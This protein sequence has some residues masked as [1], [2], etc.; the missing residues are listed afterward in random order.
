[1]KVR[2]ILFDLGNTLLCYSLHGHWRDFLHTRLQEV[3][4]TVC[5]H[6]VSHHVSPLTFATTAA[7]IIG[8]ER[9]RD[10]AHGGGTWRFDDRLRTAL[11]ALGLRCDSQHLRQATDFFYE[12]VRGRTEPYPDTIACLERLRAEGYRLAIISDTP[13]DAPGYL[14]RGDM[15]RWNLDPYFDVFYF[16]GDRPWRKPDPRV[17]E[18]AA[19]E[20][21]VELSECVIIGDMLARDIAAAN[22]A[23]IP[24]IWLDRGYGIP[25][26]P[27]AQPTVTATSLTEAVEALATLDAPPL[28]Q[29]ALNTTPPTAR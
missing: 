12:P 2:A 6:A 8:G 17:P 4:R 1:M 23:G 26:W 21:G 11:T 13:W 19:R 24:S 18:T 25:P 14:C 29:T 20:L 10:R 5:D 15:A 9:A 16:S 22:R 28:P 7:E 3:Y 27:E